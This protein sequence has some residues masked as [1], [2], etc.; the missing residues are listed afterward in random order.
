MA[1]ATNDSMRLLLHGMLL[2]ATASVREEKGLESS[3]SR[4]T[5]GRREG[6]EGSN[7]GGVEPAAKRGNDSGC[8]TAM[9]A[10]GCSARRL[11]GAAPWSMAAAAASA[12]CKVRARRLSQNEEQNVR[13]EWNV[14]EME[15]KMTRWW[16]GRPPFPQPT[17]GKVE[18]GSK[19]GLSLDLGDNGVNGEWLVEV[20]DGLHAR[21][22]DE[23]NKPPSKLTVGN[24]IMHPTT[25]L[26]TG[27]EES[28]VPHEP[29]RDGT[30]PADSLN[31]RCMK[32]T[33]R[34]K[35]RAIAAN[36]VKEEEEMRK[37]TIFG[38]KGWISASTGRLFGSRNNDGALPL[39]LSHARHCGW[40]EAVGMEVMSIPPVDGGNGEG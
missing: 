3:G 10:R 2:A 24:C 14:K 27:N 26:A 16:L 36:K 39:L 23:I 17:K 33:G 6:V 8:S 40:L 35:A 1:A 5:G 34:G 15:T 32:P 29:A 9:T 12:A 22:C 18:E 30:G 20:E 25:K 11:R 38:E 13:I 31:S 28:I 19:G 21:D 4:R 37:Y 7:I